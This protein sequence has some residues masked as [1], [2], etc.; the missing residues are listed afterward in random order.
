MPRTR[1]LTAALAVAL[2]GCSSQPAP[3]KPAS[4]RAALSS[5]PTLA[6]DADVS[7]LLPAPRQAL[8]ATLASESA[9]ALQLSAD[10]PTTAVLSIGLDWKGPKGNPADDAAEFIAR[11]QELL[12]DR[13]SKTE[14]VQS[15]E[16]TPCGATVTWDRHIGGLPVVGSRLTFHFDAQG[17]LVWVT[18]G[19]APVAST[20][21]TVKDPWALPGASSLPKM[22]GKAP[23]KSAP[24][25]KVLAP[26]HDGS[27]VFEAELVGWTDGTRSY[28]ALA[29]GDVAVSRRFDVQGDGTGRTGAGP[30]T[31]AGVGTDVPSM[32]SYRAMGNLGVAALPAERNPL[33]SAFRFLEEH[34]TLYRTGAARCQYTPTRLD[35][36]PKQPGVYTVRLAQR[37]ATLPVYGAELVVTLEGID[38]VA[39]I[40]ARAR[41]RIA[42]DPTP[43]MTKAAAISAA[44]A[45]LGP[46]VPAGWQQ[47]ANEALAAT[48]RTELVVFPQFLDRDQQTK[49][50]HLAWRVDL[51]SFTFLYDAHSGQRLFETSLRHAARVVRDA[52]GSG[53]LGLISPGYRTVSVDGVTVPPITP[54]PT[55]D[56]FPGLDGITGGLPRAVEDYNL[57]LARNGH[58]GLNGRGGGDLVV[59]T[60]VN[61][62]FGA[63]ATPNAFF[64]S[65]VTWNAFFCPGMASADV[66][67][68]ELTHGVVAATTGLVMADQSGAIN[69]AYADTLSDL[70][71]RTRNRFI[72]ETTSGFSVRDLL[73][74]ERSFPPQ[75]NHFS[76]YAPRTGAVCNGSAF[77]WDCDFGFVHTNSGIINRA[78]QLLELGVAGSFAGVGAERMEQ[79][80][81]TVV[82]TRLP[83]FATMHQVAGA[84][85]SVCEQF[86]ANGTVTSR[87]GLSYTLSHCDSVTSAFRAVGLDPA[88][89]SGW[90]EPSLG[91]FGTDTIFPPA[92]GV[93]P[94]TPGRCP[95][96]NILLEH[97]LPLLGT[98]M[99]GD[100]DPTTPMPPRTQ[101]LEFVET[102]AYN[103]TGLPSTPTSIFPMGTPVLTHRVDWTSI[104]GIKPTFAS[105]AQWPATCTPP[106]TQSR[107]SAL[108][109][110][111]FDVGNWTG[112]ETVVVGNATPASL[113]ATCTLVSSTLELLDGAG[114]ILEVGDDI[115]HTITH[116]F[117]FVPV[118]FNARAAIV[119]RP[120]G[121]N[122]SGSV[123]TSWDLGRTVRTRWRYE[124]LGAPGVDCNPL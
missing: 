4:A 3:E 74:P 1:I 79:L 50:D 112:S 17:H 93:P 47:A 84:T 83:A 111:G 30:L 88:L 33:E 119:T 109:T 39:A 18:N 22:M 20:L 118:N 94:L 73:R 57:L 78:H 16:Q 103:F 123:F 66:A 77:P 105:E 81:L 92:G 32:V 61:I 121:R 9:T 67:G 51:G 53:V 19:V 11:Y 52:Q 25:V 10:V 59:N 116:W 101:M 2:A 87:S 90:S 107:F 64:D 31:L 106:P 40:T 13:V 63:C 85:R 28:G 104:Y 58:V 44:Q 102:T 99:F 115:T 6:R 23:V 5:A 80:A 24:R 120:V 113:P 82:T 68:H 49:R 65:W 55:T 37:H 95:V 72:G 12:D 41:G 34:P 100:Y 42:I 60:N 70:A 21:V 7:A 98:T 117:L 56:I 43:T 69:E 71:D 54:A 36:N 114:N 86:V 29:L 97:R 110:R 124:F 46:P 8:L 108:V 27:G 15:K 76:G 91:F 26:M 48:P 96:T 62:E 75:P 122:M 38:Q 14:Y 35:E 45:A 89:T